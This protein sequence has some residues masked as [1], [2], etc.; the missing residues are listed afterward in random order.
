MYFVPVVTSAA[1]LGVVLGM[2]FH[3]LSRPLN[4]ALM[5]LGLLHQPL[6]LLGDPHTALPVVMLV[7]IWQLMGQKMVYFLAGLQSIPDELYEAARVDGAD[8]LQQF[9]YVTLPGLAT[10]GLVIVML[11][12]LG[13]LAVFDSVLTLTGGGPYFSS[14]VVSTYVYS[15]AFTSAHGVSDANL[16]YAAAASMFMSAIILVVTAASLALRAAK[17]RWE[18][19]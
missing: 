7:A 11:S 19:A 8:V 16:G 14:E 9:Q 12:V 6:D 2:L 17:N 4:A 5:G 15:Y 3:Q 13:S 1:I 10:V 18:A